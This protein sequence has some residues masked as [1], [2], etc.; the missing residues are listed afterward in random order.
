MSETKDS[1]SAALDG[2]PEP[3]D[4][5]ED[6]SMP[7]AQQQEEAIKKKF[8]GLMPKK[9]PLIS[10]QGVAKP[11][12]PLE[13]LRPKLQPTRQQ[14]QQRARR[15]IYTSSENEDGDSAGAEDMNI[16]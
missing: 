14:Q 8:G 6:N 1:N 7:S 11:K 9:P 3:M 16:N 13:A 4:Q 15:S 5:S 2:N 10:K 12:G